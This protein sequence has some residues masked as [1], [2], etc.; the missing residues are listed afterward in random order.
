MTMVDF[1]VSTPI[2]RLSSSPGA[3]RRAKKED[4][5]DEGETSS[6]TKSKKST[7]SKSCERPKM[8][9]AFKNLNRFSSNFTE[10]FISKLNNHHHN[11]HSHKNQS[12]MIH[13]RTVH[14]LLHSEAESH[15]PFF[16][17]DEDYSG[18]RG[19]EALQGHHRQKVQ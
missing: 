19:E 11:S 13:S 14:S 5:E 2:E 7:R 1:A 15:F 6:V 10:K 12:A 16:D 9:D 8:R 4:D 3:A 18:L 17:D